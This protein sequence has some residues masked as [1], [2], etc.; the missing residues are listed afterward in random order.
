LKIYRCDQCKKEEAGDPT[1]TLKGIAGSQ[2]GILLPGYYHEKH[3]CSPA[4]FWGWSMD[5]AE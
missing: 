3:F 2:G 4:C 1:V 5:N